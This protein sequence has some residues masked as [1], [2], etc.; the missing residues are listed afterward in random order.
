MAALEWSDALALELPLMD[1]T[2]KL[3]SDSNFRRDPRTLD[4]I[5][6]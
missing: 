5:G 1:D 4:E 2:H 6:I 3:G